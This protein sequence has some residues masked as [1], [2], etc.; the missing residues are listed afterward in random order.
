MKLIN[1]KIL[2]QI[3]YSILQVKLMIVYK[4]V[5]VVKNAKSIPKGLL[6]FLFNLLIDKLKI[7]VPKTHDIKPIT[8]DS[9]NNKY[10]YY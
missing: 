10:I 5:P 4:I 1:V 2:T 3:N 6:I 8:N 9:I 7:I